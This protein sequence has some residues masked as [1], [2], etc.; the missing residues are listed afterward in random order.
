MGRIKTQLIKRVAIKL[1]KDNPTKFKDNFDENKS[2]VT[3]T[4]EVRSTKLRNVIAGYVT[5]LVKT[6]K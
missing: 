4:A 1:V 2:L 6:K 5:R 3:E